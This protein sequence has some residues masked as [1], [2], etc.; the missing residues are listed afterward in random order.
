[1]VQ[2]DTALALYGPVDAAPGLD[3]IRRGLAA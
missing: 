2:A 1:M 3:E